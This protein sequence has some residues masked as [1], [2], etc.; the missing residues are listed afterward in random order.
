MSDEFT[1]GDLDYL[2]GITDVR[3][4]W[5]GFSDPHTGFS[6]RI[7]GSHY[8]VAIGRADVYEANGVFD[9]LPWTNVGSNLSFAASGLTLQV[10]RLHVSAVRMVNGAGMS[11]TVVSDGFVPDGMC[12]C[13]HVHVCLMPVH[14]YQSPA[15]H[16]VR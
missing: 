5:N 3:V 7:S 14:R 6:S 10:G 8:E 2:P 4:R 16:C 1:G 13:E 15:R 9:V 11:T 12:A